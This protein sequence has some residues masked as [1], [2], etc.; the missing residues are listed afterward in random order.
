MISHR[1]F[2]SVSVFH[3]VSSSITFHLEIQRVG[4]RH[5]QSLYARRIVRAEMNLSSVK[6]Y[7]EGE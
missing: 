3:E 5:V 7:A 2:R 1:P 6:M 4:Q